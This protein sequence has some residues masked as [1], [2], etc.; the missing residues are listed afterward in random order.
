MRQLELWTWWDAKVLQT[1]AGCERMDLCIGWH[2][3]VDYRGE[4]LSISSIVY[5]WNY[6]TDF[7]TA[8]PNHE[9]LLLSGNEGK[10]VLAW[11]IKQ[12]KLMKIVKLVSL[13]LRNFKDSWLW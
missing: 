8:R 6:T 3:N 13:F 11:P 7:T 2:N 4:G 9:L 10:N 5:A 1:E 12:G